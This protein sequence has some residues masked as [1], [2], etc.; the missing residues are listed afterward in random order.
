[1][2]CT[3]YVC[4]KKEKKIK[5]VVKRRRD[6]ERVGSK[7][8]DKRLK[9]KD[10]QLDTSSRVK[11]LKKFLSVYNKII[12]M[13]SSSFFVAIAQTCYNATQN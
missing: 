6:Y 3:H 7:N 12:I 13:I 5:I 10:K 2:I 1:M 4:K 9:H 11:R 8:R